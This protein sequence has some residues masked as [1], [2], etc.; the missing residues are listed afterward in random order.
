MARPVVDTANGEPL[1]VQGAI[2]TL[3]ELEGLEIGLYQRTEGITWMLWG[4]VTAGIYFTFGMFGSVYE[5]AMP[6]WARLV[7]VPW[8][9]AGVVATAAVWRSAHLSTGSPFR[10]R[11]NRRFGTLYGLVYAF[12]FMAGFWILTAVGQDWQLKEPGLVMIILGV[13][14]TAVGFLTTASASARRM[15]A[16]VG[17][18]AVAAALALAFIPYSAEWQAYAYQTLAGVGILGGG[19]FLG[20]LYLTLKG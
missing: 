9:L 14:S 19:W 4:F 8:V 1:T 5:D 2:R 12:L 13:A 7:W 10:W 18:I 20:G 6:L 17:T 11:E 15:A 3:R 16:L